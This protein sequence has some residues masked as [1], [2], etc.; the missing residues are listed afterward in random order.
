M[1]QGSDAGRCNTVN[2]MI[3]ATVG[4]TMSSWTMY[5][6]LIGHRGKKSPSIAKQNVWKRNK[7]LFSSTS[8]CFDE[9]IASYRVS[10]ARFLLH[11][12]P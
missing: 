12:I 4:C 8:K 9:G 3:I 5:A 11:A 7:S 2:I 10:T 1:K 6:L